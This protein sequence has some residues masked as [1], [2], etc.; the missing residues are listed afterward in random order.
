[1][2]PELFVAATALGLLAS[3]VANVHPRPVIIGVPS[4]IIGFFMAELARVQMIVMTVAAI[5]WIAVGGLDE[6]IGWVA[7]AFVV[8]SLGLLELAHRRGVAAT[9]V[10]A[11]ALP[12]YRAEPPDTPFLGFS[13][14]TYPG[15]DIRRD[16]P[17]GPHR[18]NR[19]DLYLPAD[20]VD[21]PIVIQVHGGGWVSGNKTQQ[22][23]PLL[24]HFT[25]AGWIG[26]AINY[27]MAPRHR[28]PAA[29]H[30]VKQ[31]IAWVRAHAEEWGGDA[32]RILLTGGSAGGHLTALC[33]LTA[34]DHTLQPGFE[35]AD[36]SVAA[37]AP[38]YGVFDLTD[39]NGHRGRKAM[40]PFL[41]RMVLTTRMKDDRA[42]WEA[43]SPLSR[44]RSDGPPMLIVSCAYDT[45]VPIGE[46]RDFGQAM[47][48]ASPAAHFVEL[49][50]AHH[51]FDVING[52]RAQGVMGAMERWASTVI[53]KGSVGA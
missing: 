2:I 28:L 49:P 3:I 14:P 42:G 11:A 30:D 47:I 45:L 53:A 10:M 7:V 12:E 19:A 36:C 48:E 6:A 24:S 33:A 29:V 44:V 9:D 40:T 39:R 18:R 26:V 4:T 23:Q 43:L 15:V 34:D 37:A 20:R 5:I 46:A 8:S 1:M 22:G 27:R 50:H 25:R 17:Y 21:A 31:T 41:E 52:P 35:E 16:L 38:M 13:R 51:A 32:D